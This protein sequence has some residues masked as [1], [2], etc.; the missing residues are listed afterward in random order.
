MIERYRDI[1]VAVIQNAPIKHWD[2]LKRGIT[3]LD[4][5]T[6][7]RFDG[8]IGHGIQLG[9]RY[10]VGCVVLQNDG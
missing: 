9:D 2:T 7:G 4:G 5:A 6:A 8:H 10:R 3:W 1:G